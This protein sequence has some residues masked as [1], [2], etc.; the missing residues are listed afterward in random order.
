M[1]QLGEQLARGSCLAPFLDG[2]ARV[3]AVNGPGTTNGLEAVR[4]PRGF[5]KVLRYASLSCCD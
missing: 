2:A 1:E 5:R 4:R 3:E